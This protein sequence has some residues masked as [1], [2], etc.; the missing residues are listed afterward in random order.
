MIAKKKAIQLRRQ[1]A[2]L[3]IQ[4]HYRGFVVRTWFKKSKKRI[5]LIQC[6]VRRRRAMKELTALKV[7]A[8]SVGK[9]KE[10]N[11]SLENKVVELSQAVV[12]K[13]K[14]KKEMAEK[15]ATLDGQ[16]HH[17]KDKFAEVDSKLKTMLGQNLGDTTALKK[18]MAELHTAKDA[19]AKDHDKLVALTKKKDDELSHAEEEITKAKEEIK[20]LKDELRNAPKV[21][22]DTGTVNS[23]KKEVT[24]LRDQLGK[25]LSGKYRGDSDA[26]MSVPSSDGSTTSAGA[27][28]VASTGTTPYTAAHYGNAPSAIPGTGSRFAAENPSPISVAVN[29]AS[30]LS[31]SGNSATSPSSSTGAGVTRRTTVS[32]QANDV[33]SEITRA[34]TLSMKDR[35]PP[36]FLSESSMVALSDSSPGLSDSDVSGSFCYI[37]G[38]Y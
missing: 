2:A 32:R 19:L 4:K 1:R 16:V 27:A 23:L 28:A 7:E 17:W 34:R 21:V 12:A 22:E 30:G 29:V 3:L 24:S 10:M 35:A 15:I 9:L 37:G 13:E 6:C 26:A 25:L 36:S 11:F 18:E 33:G 14:E 38:L 8:K 20:K 31:S 5:I